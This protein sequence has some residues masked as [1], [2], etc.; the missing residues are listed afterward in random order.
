MK[1][2]KKVLIFTAVCYVVGF[3]VSFFVNK[4]L[5]FTGRFTDWPALVGLGIGVLYG[6]VVMLDNRN[7]TDANSSF[8]GTC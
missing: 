2:L 1:K 3:I 8:E 5:D 6:I 7:Y 4:E